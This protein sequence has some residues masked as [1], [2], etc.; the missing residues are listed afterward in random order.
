[1]LPKWGRKGGVGG[2]GEVL[3]FFGLERCGEEFFERHEI[4]AEF[5]HCW[6]EI[7]F[8]CFVFRETKVTFSD[9]LVE[10]VNDVTS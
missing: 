1:M 10:E 4:F 5:Y 6:I 7:F 2:E 9:S 8:F 3:V